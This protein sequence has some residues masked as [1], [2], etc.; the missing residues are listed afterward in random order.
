MAAVAPLHAASFDGDNDAIAEDPSV[1]STAYREVWS[2]TLDEM[3]SRKFVRRFRGSYK[4]SSKSH[5]L[6]AF[7]VL[8]I[9]FGLTGMEL[10]FDEDKV[11]FNFQFSKSLSTFAYL[12]PGIS[13]IAF[14][15]VLYIL[16]RWQASM[17][18]RWALNI[19]YFTGAVLL[20]IVLIVTAAN[21]GGWWDGRCITPPSFDKQENLERAAGM[22]P[23]PQ[24][25][26]CKSDPS[27][28]E[29]VKIFRMLFFGYIVA[30]VLA[31]CIS[32]LSRACLP[33]LVQK[34]YLRH[35]RFWR[36][37]EVGPLK[38]WMQ[39]QRERERRRASRTSACSRGSALSLATAS[40]GEPP[41]L[42]VC[43]EHIP[44]ASVWLKKLL[45][46]SENT[47]GVHGS[48]TS[49]R[50]CGLFPCCCC[51]CFE[52][53]KHYAMYRGQVDSLG[54][55]HGY[56]K[57]REEELHGETL[58]GFWEHGKPV[59]P[60]KSREF[61][62]GSG[63]ACLRVGFGSYEYVKGGN[64]G[65]NGGGGRDGRSSMGVAD[66]ECSVS[67]A[68]FRDFP[69]VFVQTCTLLQTGD[70]DGEGREGVNGFC[71][72][73][74]AWCL[75]KMS[76]HMPSFEPERIDTV[77]L[78]V[79]AQ[80]GIRVSGHHPDPSVPPSLS[81]SR[82]FLSS[83]MGLGMSSS[84]E[85]DRTERDRE[86]EPLL[87]P[88]LPPPVPPQAPEGGEERE[89]RRQQ[90]QQPPA[91][92]DARL[93]LTPPS[94]SA[95]TV[96][97][98]AMDRDRDRERHFTQRRGAE[99]ADALPPAAAARAE[100]DEE[101]VEEEARRSAGQ[102]I[103]TT[104]H[105]PNGEL[106]TNAHHKGE[107]SGRPA[108]LSAPAPLLH[109]GQEPS[110]SVSFRDG[111]SKRVCAEVK[112]EV[113]VSSSSASTPAQH[114]QPRGSL[115]P[116]PPL[117]PKNAGGEREREKEEEEWEVCPDTGKSFHPALSSGNLLL[118]QQ[119][120]EGK[121]RS[122]SVRF[123]AGG[124]GV[125]TVGM[126]ED[127]EGEETFELRVR[128]WLPLRDAYSTREALVYIPGYNATLQD[129]M[130]L[131]GQLV[132]FGSFPAYVKPFVFS[133]PGKINALA[134]FQARERCYDPQCRHA[135][136]SFLGALRDAGV[137]EVHV[138]AHSMG[139]RV[140]S[141]GCREA[142]ARGLWDPLLMD[143]LEGD[144]LSEEEGG[145]PPSMASG[146]RA[147]GGSDK[148]RDREGAAR[149]SLVSVTYLNPDLELSTFL[150]A[151]FPLLE[152]LTPLVSV[153]ADNR[154]QALFYAEF[155]NLSLSMGR[156]VFG[157][158]REARAA[159]AAR[160]AAAELSMTQTQLFGVGGAFSSE[161]MQH[162]GEQEEEEDEEAQILEEGRGKGGEGGDGPASSGERGGG[163]ASTQ[164]SNPPP[165]VT[166]K[167]PESR[168]D[169]AVSSGSGIAGLGG[170][171]SETPC[172]SS[173]RRGG[174]GESFQQNNQHVSQGEGT[175]QSP[176]SKPR[177]RANRGQREKTDQQAISEKEREK[178]KFTAAFAAAAQAARSAA[179]AAVTAGQDAL[180]IGIM[181]KSELRPA[182]SIHKHLRPPLQSQSTVIIH[183]SRTAVPPS[184]GVP[185]APPSP[186]PSRKKEKTKEREGE[187]AG[188]GASQSYSL[189]PQTQLST[190]EESREREQSGGP[191]GEETPGE[192]Q[193]PPSLLAARADSRK[194]D[195][196]FGGVGHEKTED[197]EAGGVREGGRRA[198]S[199]DEGDGMTLADSGEY[200]ETKEGPKA[201]GFPSASA[202]PS[203]SA[204]ASSS[205]PHHHPVTRRR[206]SPPLHHETLLVDQTFGPS[207]GRRRRDRRRE[208][209]HALEEWLPV[210]VI[211]TSMVEQNV[212]SLRH[213]FYNMN[214]EIVEDLREIITSRRRAKDRTSRLDRREGNVWVFR[215][216]PPYVKSVTE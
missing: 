183:P 40:G 44:T 132:A 32:L 29:D 101:N 131:F 158:K 49:S 61:G 23:S 14:L 159:L 85:R 216:A 122:P 53:G 118:T 145:R 207:P 148:E 71:R 51:C 68:F 45:C 201:D 155:A 54:R 153:F 202:G 34:G 3:E 13:L 77:T 129:S 94:A 188:R 128:G 26:K 21:P 18:L 114:Q 50:G 78:S 83:R 31:I 2:D 42:S 106:P 4:K 82:R 12:E 46:R 185:P 141:E 146:R 136:A 73:A 112:V 147:T 95:T 27:A 80:R 172:S 74:A 97:S 210:D 66:V 17:H 166:V 117:R 123:E 19:T 160:L 154:D 194:G 200:T 90:Q 84:M 142:A 193:T 8:C 179:A 24:S 62:S 120:P 133:W 65:G 20:L 35:F 11:S 189:P 87:L 22:T 5:I 130:A 6:V 105:T 182:A 100:G 63:F 196:P 10:C 37:V 36:L 124:P 98:D 205:R 57:W 52:R 103:H 198:L 199:R 144:E 30:L 69:R 209:P 55:P 79:D 149:I 177:S 58:V 89:E 93:P 162:E 186:Y 126:D 56:G 109:R 165:Q 206:P 214:R 163:F 9:V 125:E 140:W 213:A 157:F 212:H 121:S 91:G 184:N 176:A 173:A 127:E 135:F 203:A 187:S 143:E 96:P 197:L 41:G 28:C 139:A 175:V 211:D 151:D 208:T 108:P 167:S 170:M 88:S 107:E 119:Q 59:A 81:R 113:V 104:P 72:E 178:S 137:R 181:S 60:Y 1:A 75:S 67:G 7:V 15:V 39:S 102:R 192:I 64:K 111:A 43:L 191:K 164:P 204:E 156:R 174:A 99:R 152:T 33:W 48:P 168:R 76:P 38:G 25:D 150:K 115:P 138:M 190:V 92:N 110:S 161:S 134:Y 169:R 16:A 116:S 70:G 195:E 47:V 215:V 86:R 171:S 180:P